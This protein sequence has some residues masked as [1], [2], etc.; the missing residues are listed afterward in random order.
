VALHYSE[1]C[2]EGLW[3]VAAARREALCLN[4]LT[5]RA[6]C[7]PD[8]RGLLLT[9]PRQALEGLPG[10]ARWLVLRPPSGPGLSLLVAA[11]LGLLQRPRLKLHS[12]ALTAALNSTLRA[13]VAKSR[14][15]LVSPTFSAAG[16]FE[17]GRR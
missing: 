2:V 16:L 17:G 7:C 3:P 6:A 12:A 9:L 8:T 4:S 11:L 10:P 14:E 1:F 5:V 13:R 15:H